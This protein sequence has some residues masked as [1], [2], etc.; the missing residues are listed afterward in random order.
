MKMRD[1]ERLYNSKMNKLQRIKPLI[2]RRKSAFTI[3]E[4]YELCKFLGIKE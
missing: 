3:Y 1:F 2:I 4:W